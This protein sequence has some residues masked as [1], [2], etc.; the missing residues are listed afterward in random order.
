MKENKIVVMKYS[1]IDSAKTLFKK[2]CDEFD[3]DSFYDEF[4]LNCFKDFEELYISGLSKVFYDDSNFDYDCFEIKGYGVFY[5]VFNE[6]LCYENPECEHENIE[7]YRDEFL[8]GDKILRSGYDV[9]L[10][11]IDEELIIDCEIEICYEDDDIEE[12]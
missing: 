9:F 5:S 10:N 3:I 1:F 8:N 4:E 6:C 12:Y 11:V 7:R 2:V